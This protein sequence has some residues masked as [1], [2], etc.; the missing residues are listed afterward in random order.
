[1]ALK[2][3]VGVLVPFTYACSGAAIFL[4]RCLSEPPEQRLLPGSSAEKYLI[5]TGKE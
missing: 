4:S 3:D 5:S 2:L 1:M